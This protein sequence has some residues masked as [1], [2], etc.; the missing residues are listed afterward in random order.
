M[1][2][3]EEIK[4]KRIRLDETQE[5][6]GKRFN[7]NHKTV[8][9]WEK[10]IT[11]APYEVIYAIHRCEERTLVG[12]FRVRQTLGMRY[13]LIKKRFCTLPDCHRVRHAKKLCKS[14]Y[15][16]KRVED[17][18]RKEVNENEKTTK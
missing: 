12:G 2:I 5:E 13:P 16:K 8:D 4:N 14:H 17:L 1:N 7:K 11:E 18:R 10:G 15:E 6:F 3:P 9:N